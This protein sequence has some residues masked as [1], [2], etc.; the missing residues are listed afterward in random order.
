MRKLLLPIIAVAGFLAFA[1]TSQAGWGC[2]GGGF[3]YGW[4]WGGRGYCG[5][6]W[7]GWGGPWWGG[8]AINIAIVRQPTVVPVYTTR[9]V[10]YE[11]VAVRPS[12]TLA[13]AQYELAKLG[14]YRGAVD[15]EFGPRTGQALVNFQ[16]DYGLPITGRLDK[17]TRLT[18]GI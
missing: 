1:G 11:R 17:R 10:V 14:Y 5:P 4:G 3:S 2:G 7:G 6:G 8:P 12:S 9:R 16:N 15:G 13:Q 18:L